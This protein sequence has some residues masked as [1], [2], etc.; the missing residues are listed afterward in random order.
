[1][2]HSPGETDHPSPNSLLQPPSLRPDR[3]LIAFTQ[4]ETPGS[5]SYAKASA[6][7]PIPA[8]TQS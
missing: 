6:D 2:D 7:R 4:N 1:L 5:P 3:C 8:T